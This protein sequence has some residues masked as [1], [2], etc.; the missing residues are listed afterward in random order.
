MKTGIND[1]RTVYPVR[2][3]ASKVLPEAAHIA[4]AAGYETENVPSFVSEG[5][6]E[7]LSAAATLPDIAGGF[8]ITGDGNITVTGKTIVVDIDTFL[9]GRMRAKSLK[10]CEYA[11]FLLATAGETIVRHIKNAR[12]AGDHLSAYI[13]DLVGSRLAESAC[14]YIQEIL[15]V[16]V[17][18]EGSSITNRYSPGYCGWNVAEQ[19]LLFNF[20]PD[21][22]CGVRL[23]KASLML[24]VKSVSGIIGVGKN[25]VRRE[26]ACGECR[27]DKCIRKIKD[28]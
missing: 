21:G 13:L 23:T 2:I 14:D 1:N 7:A 16:T 12:S 5:I 20:F 8:V 27:H 24:P 11:A 25:A 22:F 28:Q 10:C 17:K 18:E 3:P 19:R 9:P 6:E 15:S 4:C 26:Y